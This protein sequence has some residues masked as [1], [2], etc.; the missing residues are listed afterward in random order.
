M[1]LVS[2]VISFYFPPSFSQSSLFRQTSLPCWLSFQHMVIACSCTCKISF[3]KNVQ[4]SSALQECLS[5]DSVNQALEQAS[6]CSLK[7]EVAV[8]L[9]PLLTSPRIENYPCMIALPRM[10]SDHHITHHYF[11]VHKPQVQQVP[12]LVFHLIICVREHTF[13]ELPRLPLS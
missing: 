7:L 12:S 3:F 4:P 13:Q 1:S 9:T 11:S 8:L 5:R 2:K 10:F 6:L